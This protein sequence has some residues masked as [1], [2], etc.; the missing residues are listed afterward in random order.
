MIALQKDSSPRS[1]AEREEQMQLTKKFSKYRFS[2][3]NSGPFGFQSVFAV[4]SSVLDTKLGMTLN[5]MT[6]GRR[7]ASFAKP[8]P[9]KG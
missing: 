4:D 2:F 1:R 6:A 3:A 8:G 9:V 5:T 7:Y